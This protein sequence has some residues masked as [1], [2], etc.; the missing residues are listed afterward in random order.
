M[1]VDSGTTCD[2]GDLEEKVRM[3]EQRLTNRAPDQVEL[4]QDLEDANS[5]LVAERKLAIEY[6][7]QVTRILRLTE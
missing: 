1:Q 5:Q 3:L 2:Y 6:W 7:E 4:Q